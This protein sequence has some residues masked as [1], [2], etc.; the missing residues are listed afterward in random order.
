[1]A[2]NLKEAEAHAAG[3][4]IAAPSA[5]PAKSLTEALSRPQP[6]AIEIPVTVN[7][8]RTVDSSDKRE[9]FSESTA[10]VLVFPQGAVIRISTPLVPGQ[11]I[12]L[13]NEKLKKEV[14]CQVVKSKATGSA[15]A[16]VELKFTEPA[17]GFWGLIAPAPPAAPAPSPATPVAP[18]P[19]PPYSPVA[20]QPS[21]PKPITLPAALPLSQKLAVAPSPPPV[22]VPESAAPQSAAP[23]D[24]NPLNNVAPPPPPP[25][26]YSKQIAALFSV[27]E[28]HVSTQR[29]QAAPEPNPAPA[30]SVPPSE[31]LKHQ[32]ANLQASLSSL[33]FTETSATPR[34]LS[35]PPLTPDE[36]KLAV[37]GE[38]ISA[39]PLQ[40]PFPAPFSADEEVKI[41][42]W[43]AP[44]S[45]NSDSSV[46]EQPLSDEASSDS[47][48]G[49]SVDF[50]EQF[51][52]AVSDGH[53]R[54]QTAVFGGQLLGES[55]AHADGN[56]STGS[57]KGRF[58]GFAAVAI[59]IIGGGAW[60]FQ[61]YRTG[62]ITVASVS[63]SGV[64]SSSAPAHLSEVPAAETVTNPPANAV[65]PAPTASSPASSEPAKNSASIPTHPAPAAVLV[66]KNSDPAP[67]KTP[68][69]EPPKKPVLGDVHL[70]APVVKHGANFQKDGEPLPAIETNSSSAGADPLAVVGSAHRKAPAAPLTVGGDVK[71]AQLLK[72]TPPIYPTLAKTQRVS[73]DVQIDALIDTSGNVAA[74]QVISGPAMLHHA[75]LDAV[76]QWKYSPALL[77]GQP[78]SM[79]LTVTVQFRIQ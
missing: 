38:P 1:M 26:D 9:P 48:S 59:L 75:A 77:N 6:V 65:I 13:T 73:G 37:N 76:K 32:A 61:Q 21:A 58:L 16:Y 10:T 57:K 69:V 39:L 71:P 34:S 52:A 68:P 55:S 2:P 47:T 41:P 28:A 24:V 60:Y 12:F 11:L 30:S 72:S 79:H 29:S 67:G 78:T 64:I 43:L 8:A 5:P 56:P 50:G 7:G 33:L 46:V 27:P 51:D 54:P 40:K 63:P 14:V 19:M 4:T 44:T 49:V 45:A 62:T 25:T 70:A 42:A 53:R 36:P 74:V 35:T 18:K 20:A 15:G 17:A 3:T 31:D 23:Q 66:P 22:V